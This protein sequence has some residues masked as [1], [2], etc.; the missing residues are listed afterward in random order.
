MTAQ[1]DRAADTRPDVTEDGWLGGR[2]RLRQPRRGHHRAGHDALLLAAAACARSGDRVAEFGAGTGAAALALAARVPGLAPDLIEIDPALVALAQQNLALN[3]I[4]GRVIQLDL[5]AD[6]RTFAD[7]GIDP[8]SYDSVLT[9]PPFNDA[10]RLQSSPHT[11]RAAAHVAGPDLLPRWLKAARRVLKPHGRLTLI[12]RAEGVTEVLK[13]LERGFG[14]VELVPVYPMR[15]RAAIRII[16]RAVK[17]GRAPLSVQPGVI[18]REANG[19]PPAEV[20]AMLEGRRGLADAD[21]VG[22]VASGQ[23]DAPD[24]RLSRQVKGEGD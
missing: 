1:P 24:N 16:V 14:S 17:G 13:A 7:A 11:A 21:T 22:E 3:A 15:G 12:W 2:L 4:P 23:A 8:D 18:L 19:S 6:A 10:D 9:N 20:A 5:N